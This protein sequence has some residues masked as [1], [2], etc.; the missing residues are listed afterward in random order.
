MAIFFIVAWPLSKML[1]CILGKDHTT[2]YRRAQLKVLV[3]LHGEPGDTVQNQESLTRDEVMIIKVK[4]TKHSVKSCVVNCNLYVIN[5]SYTIKL[6]V[7]V[8]PIFSVVFCAALYNAIF[9]HLSLYVIS[10]TWMGF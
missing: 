1:D 2:F 3:D 4:K 5:D 7:Y 8:S 10:N 9:G 6:R